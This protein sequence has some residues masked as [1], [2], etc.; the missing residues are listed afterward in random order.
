MVSRFSGHCSMGREAWR[1]GHGVRAWSSGMEVQAWSPGMAPDAF[2]HF[3]LPVDA[4]MGALVEAPGAG[5]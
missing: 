3:G 5:M 2:S 1:S 4:L